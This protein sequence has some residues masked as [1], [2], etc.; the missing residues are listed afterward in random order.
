VT[1]AYGS[2]P[3]YIDV[4]PTLTQA[5]PPM[6]GDMV[7]DWR[8]DAN[9]TLDLRPGS[10]SPVR[11]AGENLAGFVTPVDADGNARNASGSW[12][13]GAYVY[14]PATPVEL[15]SVLVQPSSVTLAPG[16][17]ETLEAIAVCS[18]TCPAGTSYAWSTSNGLVTL[19]RTD[20]AFVMV[21]ASAVPGNAT[22]S[23][24]VTLNGVTLTAPSV[25]IAIVGSFGSSGPSGGA[26][27][28]LDLGLLTLVIVLVASVAVVLLLRRRARPG[29]PPSTPSR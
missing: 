14:A 5:Q 28:S 24:R 10:G 17:N 8:V 6:A 16:Q 7:L 2:L 13:I 15:T 23:I 11:G 1:D 29:K 25:P 3:S 4:S 20:G 9:F 19:N 18:A 12:D 26:L 22:L 27:S 21:T